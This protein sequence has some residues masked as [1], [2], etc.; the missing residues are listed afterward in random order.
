[1]PNDETT[2]AFLASI[3]SSEAPK[4]KSLAD[5]VND[6]I[7]S[8][9]GKEASVL[10]KDEVQQKET[11][12]WIGKLKDGKLDTKD[13]NTHLLSRTY[14]SNTVQPTIADYLLF[15]LAHPQISAA[16]HA[17]RLSYSSLTRHFV[18]IQSLPSLSSLLTE[19]FNPSSVSIDLD[20]VPVV[21]RPKEVKEKKPKKADTS[22]AAAPA[23]EAEKKAGAAE[24]V[25][26]EK[27]GNNGEKKEK[28]KKEKKEQ[29]AKASGGGGS[30][31]KA[32]DVGP[33]MPHMIDL[34]IGKI[35]EVKRHP[36]ADSLYVEQIDFG[37]PE[38][39]RTVVSGLV[40]Y[41]P[42]EEMENRL[43]VGVCNLKPAA[44]RGIKSFAM[45]LCA[46]SPDG[47]DGGVELV[48]PP[49]GSVPGDRTALEQL[50]PKKKQ[51]EI[52]QPGFTTL[53][54]KDCAWVDPSDKTK[55]HR[56]VSKKGV[57]KAPNFVGASLS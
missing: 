42:I 27:E 31:G 7:A 21:E 50:N 28:P 51:W 30:A 37:E 17:D 5:G 8:L 34:R 2:L 53:D 57:C 55:V 49:E 54:N 48:S 41:V 14:I 36:D 52:I 12:R 9:K 15:S 56:I 33:P 18:T 26:V 13:V 11:Q 1:M 22:S 43:L 29:P 39:P 46:T 23:K 35:V 44:M 45:V 3:Y 4:G 19:F 32:A 25:K 38:G 16:T 24:T 6:L 10:G 47:K 20:D 40:K